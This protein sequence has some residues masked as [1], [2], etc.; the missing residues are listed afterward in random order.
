MK[1]PLTKGVVSGGKERRK[2]KAQAM[3]DFENILDTA[4][5]K[6]HIHGHDSACLSIAHKAEVAKAVK[7]ERERKLQKVEGLQSYE[8]AESIA[9]PMPPGYPYGYLWKK[10]VLT[11]LEADHE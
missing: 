11:I 6:G 3:T 7:A 10:D 1:T 2:G 9:K 5:A 4:I 8:Y